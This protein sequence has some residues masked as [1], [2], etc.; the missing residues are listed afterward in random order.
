MFNVHQATQ[1]LEHWDELSNVTFIGHSHLT[2]AFSLD[3][4]EGARDI[5]EDVLTFDPDKKYIV[6]VGSV[7]QPRDNDNRACCGIF[8][9]EARTFEYQRLEYNIREAARKIFQA[10]L[11]SDFAKRLFFGI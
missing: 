5:S 11:S 1:L 6:T 2:K 3:K 10:D 8:D 9:T 4:E 7:G